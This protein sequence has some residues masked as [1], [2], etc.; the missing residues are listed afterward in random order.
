MAYAHTHVYVGYSVDISDI[1]PHLRSGAY[2]ITMEHCADN[3]RPKP[4][5][6]ITLIV[7][8]SMYMEWA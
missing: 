4:N 1:E 7:R 2:M 5:I 8:R 6:V 3:S